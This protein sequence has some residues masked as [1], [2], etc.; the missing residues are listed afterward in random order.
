[1]R[2]ETGRTHQIRVHLSSIGHPILG[3]DLYG[4]GRKYLDR[5]A[6]LYRP[7]AKKV[8][9]AA[10]RVMLHAERIE[11]KHPVSGKAIKFTAPL[12]DDM[13]KVISML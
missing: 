3:D 9:S 1:M 4:G 13:K 8:V 6:P 2:P 5:I 7:A 12:P 11:F 10:G